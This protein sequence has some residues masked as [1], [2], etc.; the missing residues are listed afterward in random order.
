MCKYTA[1]LFIYQKSNNKLIKIMRTEKE[2]KKIGT[3]MVREM[4]VGQ[5]QTV[6]GLTY[7]EVKSAQSICWQVEKSY[8]VKTQVKYAEKVDG[9]YEVTVKRVG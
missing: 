9:L 8:G 3:K 2:K 5:Q 6:C 4:E 1:F 7:K